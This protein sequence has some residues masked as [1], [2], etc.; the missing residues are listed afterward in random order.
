MS[1]PRLVVALDVHD[2]SRAATLVA[3]L[4]P[5]GVLFKV[6]YE[7]FYGYADQ[8]REELTRRAAGYALDLKL[9]D[10]PNTVHAAVRAVVRPGVRL[11]TVHALGGATMLETAVEAAR[12]R[13][14]EL[15]IPAP[16]VYAVTILTSIGAEEL[17]ELG[18]G[19]GPGE[20]AIRLAA[21]ARDARCSGVVC[22]VRE[23]PSLKSFFG[24]EFGTFCPGIRPSGSAHGDQKRAATPREA[25]EAGA[26]YVVVGRPIIEDADPLNAARAILTELV[27]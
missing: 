27:G 15:S 26:D 23:V 4:A 7:A 11:L 8:I 10:I 21:L 13:A 1:A 17:G 9:H 14:A 12:E 5:L 3:T 20:N 22:S 19:G 6:G 16:D 25:R 2:P 18:L 24:T